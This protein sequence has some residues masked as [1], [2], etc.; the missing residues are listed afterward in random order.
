MIGDSNTCSLKFG[1]DPKRSFGKHLPG[2]QVYAPLISDIKPTDACGFM[3]V[4]VLC[5]VNNIKHTDVKTPADIKNIFK[6]FV[7]KINDI[8]A[9]NKK[10]HVYVCPLLPTKCS[11]LNRRVSFFNH[12]IYTELL[13]F[14]FGV[15]LVGGFGCLIDDNGFL[16]QDLSRK[17][18]RFGR[19]DYLH[20]NW[21]GVAKVATILKNT[22][23]LRVN[24]GQDRR[25]GRRGR[26]VDGTLFADVA[27]NRTDRQ[28]LG[29]QDGYQSE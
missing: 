9:A 28:P 19:P 24:G 11:D 16:S 3:N 29:H 21:R 14:N 25:V 13:P 5:G 12:L 10:A 6:C 7:N 22:I 26:R 8:Q 17:V 23:L 4:A 1:E 18:N 27:G 15:T 20:L 2:R